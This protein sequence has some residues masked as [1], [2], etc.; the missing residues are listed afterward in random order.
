MVNSIS[1]SLKT[2][3]LKKKLEN[4]AHANSVKELKNTVVNAGLNTLCKK[5][6]GSGIMLTNKTKD[7]IKKIRPLENFIEKEY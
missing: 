3:H 4:E 1:E 2:I 7:I 5:V 6:I